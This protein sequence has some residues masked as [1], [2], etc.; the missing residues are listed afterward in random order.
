MNV[1]VYGTGE[2]AKNN[3]DF[4]QQNKDLIH[5]KNFT[6]TT[7]SKSKFYGY[8]VKP[9]SELNLDDI[10]RYVSRRRSGTIS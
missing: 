2:I 5:I 10:D 8:E 7:P 1:I 6:E 9:A 3:M 4:F